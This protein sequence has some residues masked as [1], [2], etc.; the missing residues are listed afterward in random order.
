MIEAWVESWTTRDW[1]MLVGVLLVI[2]GVLLFVLWPR[3]TSPDQV[4]V[5]VVNGPTVIS[6]Q[7]VPLH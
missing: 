3:P 2:I 6:T 7:V 1:L 5:R 4:T